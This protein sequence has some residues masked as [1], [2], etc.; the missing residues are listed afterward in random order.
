MRE[1][2]PGFLFVPPHNVSQWYI[3]STGALRYD[4]PPGP[5]SVNDISMLLPFSDT[6]WAV[7]GV[8][9]AASCS[10]CCRR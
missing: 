7:Q 8:R 10:K 4:L 6:L 2:A 1:V 3:T 5:L 9:V